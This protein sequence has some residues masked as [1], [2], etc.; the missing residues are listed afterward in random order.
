MR[1][2]E[3]FVRLIATSF[4][5]PGEAYG[6]VSIFVSLVLGLPVS[7]T[8]SVSSGVMKRAWTLIKVSVELLPKGMPLSEVNRPPGG[9]FSARFG[10]GTSAVVLETSPNVYACEAV[11]HFEGYGMGKVCTNI[12]PPCVADK[13]STLL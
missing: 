6:M 4:G 11:G 12:C 3:L 5:P 9:V 13:D 2:T 1:A 10:Y 8:Q 7:R